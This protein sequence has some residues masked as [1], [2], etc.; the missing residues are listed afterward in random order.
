MVSIRRVFFLIL[1]Y[2]LTYIFSCF[3]KLNTYY[4]NPVRHNQTVISERLCPDTGYL[5][6][7]LF[8]FNYT[9][10]CAQLLATKSQ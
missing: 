1:V 8:N 7:H 2:F 6:L 4:I 10:I 9:E 3:Y 5:H